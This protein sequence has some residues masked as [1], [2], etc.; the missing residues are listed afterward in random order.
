MANKISFPRIIAFLREDGANLPEDAFGQ[1]K[2]SLKIREADSKLIL[3]YAASDREL[4]RLV[5]RCVGDRVEARA[6]ETG[7]EIEM[8]EACDSLVFLG[9]T[10]QHKKLLAYAEA[11]G[12]HLCSVSPDGRIHGLHGLG[13]M[14][15]HSSDDW[16][17]SVFKAADLSSDA[18]LETIFRQTDALETRDTLS[19]REF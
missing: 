10:R 19:R 14:N 5:G 3:A 4:C 8:I 12:R 15:L 1:F 18:D 17:P 9:E 16:L 6:F 11:L 13:E 7:S 2:A